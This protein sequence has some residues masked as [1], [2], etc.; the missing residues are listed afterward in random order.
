MAGNKGMKRQMNG[1]GRGCLR[2]MYCSV[3]QFTPS[4]KFSLHSSE[5]H[6]ERLNAGCVA[7]NA[8]VVCPKEVWMHMQLAQSAKVMLWYTDGDP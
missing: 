7:H 6:T 3:H 8:T 2:F 5:E 4:I 1:E